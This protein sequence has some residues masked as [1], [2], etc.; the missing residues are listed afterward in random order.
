M[1]AVF[2]SETLG[3]T[4]RLIMLSLADHADDTG[5][6]YPSITRLAR[7]TG[8]SERA[9]QTNMRGLQAKGYLSI[10]ANE[11]KGGVNVYFVRATPAADAPPQQ[12]HPRSRCTLPPQQVHP[13][14]QEP[15]LN[16]HLLLVGAGHRSM[17]SGLLGPCPRSARTR[18]SGHGRGFHRTSA[19]LR[20]S[21]PPNG[22]VPGG[23]QIP[24]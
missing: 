22:A 4:E 23:S 2:E 17:I 14:H 16:R 19:V 20:K 10:A 5:R 8:L 1:S 3:P 24:G 12:M 21:A 11:G 15:S 6:C 9:I 18:R 7:R 13:N